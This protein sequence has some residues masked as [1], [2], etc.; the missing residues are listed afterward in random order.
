MVESGVFKLS[1][2]AVPAWGNRTI[3]FKGS[4]VFDVPGCDGPLTQMRPENPLFQGTGRGAVLP[5][6]IKR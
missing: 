6:T 3:T 5:I 1:L 4:G 2:G